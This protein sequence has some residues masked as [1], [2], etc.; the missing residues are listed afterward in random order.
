MFMKNK[1]KDINVKSAYLHLMSD[2][3]VSVGIVIAGVIIYFTHFLF[4]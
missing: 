2:A 3:L 1:E 4:D